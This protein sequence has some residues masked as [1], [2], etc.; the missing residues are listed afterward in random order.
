[1]V[2]KPVV[3]SGLMVAA[4]ASQIGYQ[5]YREDQREIEQ[6]RAQW[7]EAQQAQ[8]LR[9]TVAKS[10]DE[11]ARFRKRLPPEPET[12]WLIREVGRLAESAGVELTSITPQTPRQFQDVTYLAVA[13]RLST[14]Y[15]TL[16]KFLA[17][18]ESARDFLRVD[19][20]EVQQQAGGASAAASRPAQV[21]LTVS[22]LYV[23]DPSRMATLTSKGR[24]ARDGKH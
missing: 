2:V 12:A 17:T 15:H 4:F 11:V 3:I 7:Q 14:S 16:G 21:K 6:V 5:G 8:A 19:E 13:L 1:M 10:L 9:A 24:G 18:L 20:L 23:P 22:T